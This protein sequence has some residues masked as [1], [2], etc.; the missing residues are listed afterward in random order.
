M[1]D[2]LHTTAHAS[3]AVILEGLTPEQATTRPR[4]LPHSVAE[5]VAH[6]LFWAEW[7]LDAADGNPPPEVPHA[8]DSWPAVRPEEWETLRVRFL[9]TIERASALEQARLDR[10]LLEGEWFGWE[11][12]TL[13][14]ALAD[15]A[16][17][18]AHHLGQAV[19][20][21]Q[22]LGVWPP[23]SGGVTW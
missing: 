5:L 18:I 8:E 10:P 12:H 3:P 16:L 13:G 11:R 20:V 6:L 14:S 2:L 15:T 4:G 19:T 7:T 22:L 1:H 23:P 9:A 17:H 21:R